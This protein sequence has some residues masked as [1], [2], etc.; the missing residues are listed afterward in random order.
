MQKPF[1]I[2]DAQLCELRDPSTRDAAFDRLITSCLKPLY[3]HARRLVVV[4]EDAEDAVQETL[5][6]AYKG[7]GGFRGD[8]AAFRAWLYRIATNRALSMLGKR[9]RSL[10][11]PLDRVSG[12]LA[13]RLSEETAPDADALLVSFQ[14]A[15]LRLPL[16]QRLVFNLRYYDQLP[17]AQIAEVLRQR[18][19]TLRVNYHLAVCALKRQLTEQ[20]P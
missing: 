7:L 10:L 9:R 4:H 3:W 20:L 1:A 18:E 8:A 14:Q 12:A 5:I 19:K 15:V 16:K 2:T 11:T 6:R 13:G 17:Y